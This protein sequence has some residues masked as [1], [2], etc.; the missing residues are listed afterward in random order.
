MRLSRIFAVVAAV[1]ALECN[2]LAQPAVSAVLNGASYSAVVAPGS[3]IAIF[4]TNLGATSQTAS[5]S[6]S[7]SLAGV[8]VS[9]GGVKA[10]LLY[11]S[12]N[13][14]NA[15]TPLDVVIPAS[16]VVPLVVTAPGGNST[17]YTLRLTR[18][19][20][21]IFTRNGGGTGRALVFDAGFK[22]VDTVGAKDIVILYA[23]GL[24]PA[25]NSGAVIDTVEVYIGE[26]Q[27]QVLS[28]TLSPGFPGVYQL[29]VAA[30]VPATDRLYVRVGGWQSNIVDVGIRSGANATNVAGSIEGLYP[31]TDP[32]FNLPPCLDELSTTP[33]NAGQTF[34]IMLHAASFNLSFDIVPSADPF[35]VAVVGIG[36]AS[37]ISVNPTS[38]T[39]TASVTTLTQ[40]ATRG[41]FSKSIVQLW[42]YSSCDNSL[43]CFAFPGPSVLPASRIDPYWLQATRLLPVPSLTTATSPNA[44][45][46]FSGSLSGRRLVIDGQTN[47]ALS[48]FGGIV[49]V[50][51]GPFDKSVSTF[52]MY[53]DGSL[54]TSKDYSYR[55]VYRQT[56]PAK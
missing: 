35:D 42:D 44:I 24:G 41:D 18:N 27:A 17:P 46:Q 47:T 50:P 11:V 13:Q 9:V 22:A 31:S 16:T 7:N 56:I 8:S 49:Q 29:N 45:A 25:D 10:P 55:V 14:I 43:V 37:V 39:Y 2:A 36:G 34:S 3:W 48:R 20:P 15:L 52:K 53:V 19:A 51:L 33:C 40:E 1:S 26:R 28:A 5:G 6:L 54:V 32:F 4:G 23:T 12:P 21:G 30:P 38:G